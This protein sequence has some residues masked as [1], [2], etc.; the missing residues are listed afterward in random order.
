MRN[1][2]QPTAASHK[3]DAIL[4]LINTPLRMCRG[5]HTSLQNCYRH[6]VSDY[7]MK[8]YVKTFF[9]F[10]DQLFRFLEHTQ[11][12]E[13]AISGATTVKGLKPP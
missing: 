2:W 4:R 7:D 1:W 10:E 8:H 12:F 6:F 11:D 5:R 3:S 13:V 9:L